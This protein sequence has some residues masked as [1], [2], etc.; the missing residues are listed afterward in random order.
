MPAT[1]KAVNGFD[2]VPLAS[3]WSGSMA[4]VFPDGD[5][6]RS[7]GCSPVDGRI[8]S[9]TNRRLNGGGAGTGINNIYSANLVTGYVSARF[10]FTSFPADGDNLTALIEFYNDVEAG[11]ALSLVIDNTGRLHLYNVGTLASPA[12]LASGSTL[13]LNTWYTLELRYTANRA[14]QP[15]ANPPWETDAVAGVKVDGVLDMTAVGD[16]AGVNDHTGFNRKA[17]VNKV[18]ICMGQ[19]ATASASF[20][21]ATTVYGF[22]DNVACAEGDYA[23]RSHVMAVTP[24]GLGSFATGWGVTTG[25]DELVCQD[26]PCDD[27]T[28]SFSSTTSQ[29]EVTFTIP[30]LR[31]LGVDA[32]TRYVMLAVLAGSSTGTIEAT[33]VINGVATRTSIALSTGAW[34]LARF[35]STTIQPDDVVEIGLRKDATVTVRRFVRL[36]LIT[37]V[38]AGN[39]TPTSRGADVQVAYGSYTGNGTQ[40]EI[41]AGFDPDLVIVSNASG[42]GTHPIFKMRNQSGYPMHVFQVYD[43]DASDGRALSRYTS[44]GFVVRS[45]SLAN[46]N[47]VAYDW[48]AIKDPS[49][50]C[51]QYGAWRTWSALD[52]ED[53]KFY[54]NPTFTPELAFFQSCARS[55][56]NV[57]A[58]IRGAG[59]TGDKANAYAASAVGTYEQAD[60]IQA[61][62]ADGFEIGTG[63]RVVGTEW[64][65]YVAARDS[66]WNSATLWEVFNYTGDGVDGKDISLPASMALKTPRMIFVQPVAYPGVATNGYVW[67]PSLAAGSS[68][69]MASAAI[70]AGGVT[71]VAVGQFTASVAAN[72]LGYDYFAWVLTDGTDLDVVTILVPE[73]DPNP[74]DDPGPGPCRGRIGCDKSPTDDPW[75]LDWPDDVPGLLGVLVGIRR[76]VNLIPDDRRSYKVACEQRTFPA[77]VDTFEFDVST[78]RR[79]Y[80]ALAEYP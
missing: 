34:T 48:V 44:T 23:G 4:R 66:A 54:V 53:V 22:V 39:Y 35:S 28:D 43:G 67:T 59:H 51:I 33:V 14:T 76:V 70:A 2:I 80:D 30:T 31:S 56:S 60:K 49:Q 9:I 36:V 27:T 61:M 26:H 32:D 47:T 57:N 13:S 71:A 78:E 37:E 72:R 52:D 18:S 62:N 8:S 16:P 68:K 7:G 74:D 69:S 42:T 6:D 19:S 63:A 29:D 25:N 46:A 50:R 5:P 10:K 77:G 41:N 58:W 79:E 3:H 55:A 65:S 20:C 15:A 73:D 12:V 75:W 45:T 24:T 64:I 1:I 38:P 17:Y 40:Q 11:P 21:T